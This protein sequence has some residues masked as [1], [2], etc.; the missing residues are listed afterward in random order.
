M[1]GAAVTEYEVV[2]VGGGP[3]GLASALFL[4]ALRPDLTDRVVVLERAKY[5]REKFC[6]GGIGARADKLLESAGVTV[7]VPSVQLS[8]IAFRCQH[9]ERV[10]RE[11]E[12]G[13][14]VR[15]KEFDHELARQVMARGVELLEG[16]PL[17][18]LWR[19]AG[20]VMLSTP[21]GE[22][23]ARVVIGA[24]GVGSLV[25]RSLG[26]SATRYRAQALEVD[27]E[28]VS[29]DLPRDTILFDV[30]RREL[31]GYYW[32]FPTLV[33]GRELMCRGVYLLKGAAQ[34]GEAD[35]QAVLAEELAARGL[36]LSRCRQK[37]YA[38]RGFEA[39]V[40]MSA[41]Q[42]LLVGEAAGIDPISGEGIAQA[43]QYGHTAASYLAARLTGSVSSDDLRF[44]DWPRA[45][46]G[47]SV[48]RDLRVR[49]L[50]VELFYGRWRDTI[51][52]FVLRYP[53]FLQ[54]GMRHF[55]GKPWGRANLLRV[56]SASL[57]HTTRALALG[58]DV[59]RGL[60]SL[61]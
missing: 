30:T 61:G 22:L 25:R 26:L 1:P 16:A 9:G 27:T 54:V 43:I 32:D 7:D 42:V 40:P 51:E 33:E 37:R 47:S 28:P 56:A 23:S 55:G 24:D 21:R 13:R 6:A 45:V 58:D 53:D 17:T 38:E 50:G 48:G 15:R 4:T 11:P 41:P 36:D 60:M 29:S 34:A 14:V 39:H 8:S 19:R 18:R 57:L 59:E 35:I 2:I 10:G 52:R 3:A 20:R 44:E 46:R 12:I 49:S 31:P 5:P